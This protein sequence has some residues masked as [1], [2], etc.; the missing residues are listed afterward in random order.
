MAKM[1]DIILS[2]PASGSPDV[3]SYKMYY[4]IAP[5]AVTYD[6][7]SVL[8]NATSVKLNDIPALQGI[9]GKC[10]IGVTAMDDGGNESDMSKLGDV[11]LDLGAPEAPGPLSIS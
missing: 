10:N 3:V 6:S 2:F 8:L 1:K 11:P 5:K 7:P 9:D 4:E